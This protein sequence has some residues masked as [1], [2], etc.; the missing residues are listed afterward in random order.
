[1]HYESRVGHLGGNLS[2]LDDLAGLLSRVIGRTTSS[3][4]PRATRPG[5]FISPSGRSGRLRED[6]LSQFHGDRPC[7]AA[8]RA[9]WRREIPFA[10]G[11]LG[12]GLSLAAGIALGKR[13]QGEPGRVFC[14]PSDGEWQRAPP[15]RRSSSP[16]HHRHGPSDD[17]G[18]RQRSA[19]FRHHAGG[20][21]PGADGARS[22]AASAC[23]PMEIDG[24]DLE[25]D[26]LPL[27]SAAPP[28]PA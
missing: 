20:C 2:A 27:A 19:G 18:R 14:L 17:A 6:D 16:S 22:S 4:C 15:G 5:L 13:I 1:M 11:S 25:A 10:T 26:P 12:H 8:I 3:C 28:A 7:S 21:R 23:R 9:G 24:H